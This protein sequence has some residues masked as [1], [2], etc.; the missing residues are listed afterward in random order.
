M[1]RRSLDAQG[2]DGTAEGRGR[3]SRQPSPEDIDGRAAR[4]LAS[5]RLRLGLLAAVLLAASLGVVLTGGPSRREI[6][7]AVNEAGAAAPLLFVALYAVLTVLFFPGS[8][9]T[10]AGGLLFGTGLGTLLA[11]IGATTGATAAFLLGRRLGRRQVEQIAGRRIG[12]V[13]RWLE[14]NGFLAVLYLR[15]IP[16]I[17]FNGLNYAAGVSALRTRDYALGTAVGIVPGAF[18]FAALGGSL[19]DPTSPEFLAAVALVLLL[20]VGA[21]LANR[22]LRKRNRGVPDDEGEGPWED[23]GGREGEAR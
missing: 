5:P 3:A 12:A 8:V 9:L 13:D 6:E 2:E 10:G 17:P 11:V 23:D 22:A 15:L 14:Q 1:K 4:A 7:D 20:A 21:P 19:D 16:V 18:A